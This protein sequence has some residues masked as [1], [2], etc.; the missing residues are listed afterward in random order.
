MRAAL[1]NAGLQPGDISYVEAHGT[2]TPLGDPIEMGSINGVFGG[3]HDSR[4]PVT[5]ASLKSN[6]GHMEAAAGIG[7][8]V[9]VILQLQAGQFFPHLIQTP[10]GRIPWDTYP[11]TIP[12][13]ARP[14]RA[15]V[16][17]AMVNGFGVAGA[18]GIAVL[19]EAPGRGRKRRPG[20][21]RAR[22]QSPARQPG[23]EVFTLSAK[24]GP[25]LRMQMAR[26]RDYLAE[27]SGV[28]L[29]DLCYTRN[30]GRS[31]FRYRM[32]AVV[33]GT[34]QLTKLL[35]E[36]LAVASE[37]EPAGY[38]KVAMLFPGSGSQYPGMGSDLYERFPTFRAHVEECDELMAAHLGRS[39][40]DIM[41][42]RVP[43]AQEVLA[44]TVFTHAALF[45]LEYA[46]AKLWLSWGIRPSVLLGH[47][48]GEVVAATVAGLFSLPDGVAFL[49]RRAELIESAAPGG[50]AAVTAPVSE[51]TP[52]LAQWR[53]LAVAAINAPA[54]CV[55]S[56]A[57]GS[58]AAAT[59]ALTARGIPV[60]PLRVATAFHSPLV[61]GIAGELRAALSGVQF[62]EPALTIM[63]N[64]TGAVAPPRVMGTPDYWARHAG[65]TVNFAAGA[66]AVGKRGKHVFLEAGPSMTLTVLA[67]ECLPGGGHTWL[68]C[69]HPRDQAGEMIDRALAGMYTAGLSIT[70]AEVYA[71]RSCRRMPLPGYVFDRHRY[72]LP[73]RDVA[74]MPD[75]GT[76]S[77]AGTPAL[78]PPKAAG[79]GGTGEAA[80]PGRCGATGDFLRNA[81]ADLVSADGPQSIDPH[82]TFL[83]L[84]IDS[85]AAVKLMA[86][87]ET[88]VG[89]P[90]TAAD[91]FDH[92]SVDELAAFIDG[93]L[94]AGGRR[95]GG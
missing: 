14:W 56:G 58:L 93:Q 45:A 39:V 29:D 70:W 54:Q 34:G 12:V 19:E 86:T 1:A 62:H 31:H 52:V 51:I 47:S 2:G 65:E 94:A 69:L 79:T 73:A 38:R 87:L 85:I 92:P 16:R 21:G 50:M 26:Y 80:G 75:S 83:E 36:R 88:H 68:S 30:T 20:E 61:A 84:G 6:L 64:L 4:N 48:V 76:A 59:A 11:V 95:D 41:L 27:H 46:L 66:R 82:A 71:G 53:D 44:R 23:G 74:A 13:S 3:S 32:A 18:I 90:V 60:R 63:S 15:P 89:L 33:G 81:V 9:K 40:A 57:A 28:R 91:M 77:G 78:P 72:G 22:A 37:P 25:A 43:G 49:M 10:S 24:S 35:D 5:V 55:I 17:R 42:G 67:R 7:A 8:V